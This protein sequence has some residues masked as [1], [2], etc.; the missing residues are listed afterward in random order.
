MPASQGLVRGRSHLVMIAGLL[1]AGGII[2][3]LERS[4][5]ADDPA[6]PAIAASDRREAA[7][8]AWNAARTDDP[9]I[10]ALARRLGVD[11]RAPARPPAMSAGA[12]RAVLWALAR[13]Q[14]SSA[15]AKR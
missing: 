8:V 4:A 14:A 12:G 3:S 11:T 9:R 5:L 7:E 10:V 13:Q 15:A 1:A 6:A 2:L